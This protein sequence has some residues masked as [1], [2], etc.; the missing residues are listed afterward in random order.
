TNAHELRKKVKLLGYQLR[1]I[2]PLNPTAIDALG[3]DLTRLGDLLGRLHDLSSLG[4]RLQAGN[5]A[6]NRTRHRDPL[7]TMTK[8]QQTELLGEATS[9]ASKVFLK[10][11]YAFGSQIEEWMTDAPQTN[12]ISLANALPQI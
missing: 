7:L 6:A 3:N 5:Q 2:R 4:N 8:K 12:M 9:L 1:I 11:P 10:A